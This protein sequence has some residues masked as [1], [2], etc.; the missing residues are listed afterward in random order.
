LQLNKTIS[1]YS[2][3]KHKDLLQKVAIRDKQTSCIYCWCFRCLT[4]NQVTV[5]PIEA[6][7]LAVVKRCYL[8]R[9]YGN[10]LGIFH[11]FLPSLF[12][13]PL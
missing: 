1:T 3:V 7:F 13:L 10:S 2:S 12:L 11:T 9:S 8:Y 4:N 6:I 5:F